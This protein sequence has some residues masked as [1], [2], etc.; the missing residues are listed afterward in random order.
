MKN[1]SILKSALVFI[2]LFN[3]IFLGVAIFYYDI[4]SLPGSMFD[5]LSR[6]TLDW[7]YNRTKVPYEDTVSFIVQMSKIIFPILFLGVFSYIL[8]DEKNENLNTKGMVVYVIIGHTIL[9]LIYA[10]MQYNLEYYR[11][12]MELIPVEV[13]SLVLLATILNI[14]RR[15]RFTSHTN[16][17][18]IINK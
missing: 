13:F 14:K 7:Y 8:L 16:T 10:Y 5:D 4:V 11:L 2:I 17:I 18:D 1:D 12:F 9:G 3:I 6:E 15:N